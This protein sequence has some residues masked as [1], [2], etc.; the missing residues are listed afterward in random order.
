MQIAVLAVAVGTTAPAQ[1]PTPTSTPRVAPSV[2]LLD[3]LYPGQFGAATQPTS[4]GAAL[5]TATAT[6]RILRPPPAAVTR[7]TTNT[8][9]PTDR[10]TTP[11]TPTTA[12]PIRRGAPAPPTRASV[13]LAP[14]VR[15]DLFDSTSTLAQLLDQ[16]PAPAVRL[17][18]EEPAAAAGARPAPA[19]PRRVRLNAAPAA[20]LMEKLKIDARRARLIVEFRELFGPFRTPEDLGQVTGLNDLM[21]RQ[22]ESAGML[23][24]E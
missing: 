21:I 4:A 3:R 23:D 1:R 2:Q 8:A 16:P 7:P 12:T 15:L 24:F 13:R 20:E 9:R 6:L 11:T 14:P 22:W 17:G 5:T 19:Q 10:P 18:G